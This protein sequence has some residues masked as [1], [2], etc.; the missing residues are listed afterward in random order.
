MRFIP[1]GFMR[2][3]LN[4]IPTP[5][6]CFNQTVAQS[7]GFTDIK[8]KYNSLTNNI[9]IIGFFNKLSY[10]LP[11]PIITTNN[12]LNELSYEGVINTG[13]TIGTG[14]NNNAGTID[15]QSD[16][17]L[18]IGGNF[19]TYS[20][21]TTNRI[22]R[23]NTNYTKDTSFNMGTGF[24]SNSVFNVKVQ[25]DNKILVTGNFTSYNGV[26]VPK[27]LRL[28]SDGT[29]DTAFNSNVTS[30][31]L[32]DADIPQSRPIIIQPDGK[33][34]T[35]GLSYSTAQGLVRLNSDGTVDTSFST[36]MGIG[37][38]SGGY[39]EAVNGM[40]LQADGKIVCTG[41]FSTFNTGSTV[42]QQSILR[43]NSNG[44]FDSTFNVPFGS[45]TFYSFSPMVQYI[46]SSGKIL[47]GGDTSYGLPKF[48]RL[49][50]NGTI[51]NTFGYDAIFQ[52]GTPHSFE[53]LPN[54]KILFSYEINGGFVPIWAARMNSN[55][56]EDIC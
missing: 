13:I 51:D 24:N 2:G 52:N 42:N 6:V 4:T 33:I 56:S 15:Y 53:I 38:N 3:G 25:S 16:G 22:I 36:N 39:P 50:T 48:T 41:D 11:G 26:T 7:S 9:N 44:T 49:N 54:E 47:C 31:S 37:F 18:I 19:T 8:V 43:L 55:G 14:F 32:V 1:F 35:G 27:I 10:T 5:E 45:S 29:L 40:C 28:N 30:A 20:G 46:P 23:L 21:I 34:L 17:K 12:S